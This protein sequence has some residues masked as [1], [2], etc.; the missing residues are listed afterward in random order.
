MSIKN[1]IYVY[2][3]VHN[4]SRLARHVGRNWEKPRLIWGDPSAGTFKNNVLKYG[5]RYLIFI[6]YI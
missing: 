1:V 5:N 4:A 2:K 6:F 3:T